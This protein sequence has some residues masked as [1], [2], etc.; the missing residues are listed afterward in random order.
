MKNRI[1]SLLLLF[2]LLASSAPIAGAWA[3]ADPYNPALKYSGK[4]TAD[5]LYY[6]NPGNPIWNHGFKFTYP[7]G[8]LCKDALKHFMSNGKWQGHLRSDGSCG[9]TAEPAEWAV[10]N[11]LNYDASSPTGR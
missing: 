7:K 9:P 2:A 11:R 6:Q 10:G 5:L 8:V 4:Y 1:C 3:A